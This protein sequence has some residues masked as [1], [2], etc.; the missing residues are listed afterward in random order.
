[1]QTKTQLILFT[2]LF[3]N[4]AFAIDCFDIENYTDFSYYRESDL[5]QRSGMVYECKVGGWCKQGGPYTPGIGWAWHQAWE[6]LGQCYLKPHLS[7]V[8]Y[9]QFCFGQYYA[10]G[11]IV[12]HRGHLYECKVDG[13]C[14]SVA[15]AY[16]P[17]EGAAW[18]DAWRSVR[19]Y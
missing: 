16:E 14:S 17:G 13:W 11:D 3:S 15:T 6:K 18:F 4:S 10:V 5:V 12:F 8:S 1:M 19:H 9:E 7:N 2:V